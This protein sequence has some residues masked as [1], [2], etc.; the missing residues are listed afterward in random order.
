[1]G[2][3]TARCRKAAVPGPSSMVLPNSAGMPAVWAVCTSRWAR[4]RPAAL[5][6]DDVDDVDGPVSGQGGT[7]DVPEVG[8]V[9]DD[10]YGDLPAHP[11]Q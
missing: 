8:D 5:R 3:A 1:M 9:F 10:V 2:E 4:R 7:Q 11:R 6:G